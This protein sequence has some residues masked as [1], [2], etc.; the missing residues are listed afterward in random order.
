MFIGM[1]DNLL[2]SMNIH[3]LNIKENDKFDENTMEAVDVL[4]DN[5]K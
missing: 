5:N 1:F 4:V 3:K 2:T